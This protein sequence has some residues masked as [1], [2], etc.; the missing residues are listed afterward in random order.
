MNIVITLP[1]EL[2]RKIQRGEKQVEIRKFAPESFYPS[3]DIVY[4]CE[5]RKSAI[6]AYLELTRIIR[7]RKELINV[8]RCARKAAIP[9]K[10]LLH[11]ISSVQYFYEW[12]IA[13][14]TT[15]DT[16]IPISKIDGLKKAPQS[17][18]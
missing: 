6:V 9:M 18:V 10:R 7:L 17:Y 16:P 14:I 15:L 12:Q 5:K 2:I 4:I 1:S 13:V 8:V 3:I 11:N